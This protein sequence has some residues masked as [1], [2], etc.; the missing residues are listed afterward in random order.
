MTTHSNAFSLIETIITLAIAG[1]LLAIAIPSYRHHLAKVHRHQAQHA[2][3]Q[4]ATNLTH[5]YR[6]IG[7]YHT[8]SNKALNVPRLEKPLKYRLRISYPAA[9]K[10]IVTATPTGR[11]AQLDK[12]CGVLQI[13][14][15]DQRFA[16]G[17]TS[18]TDCWR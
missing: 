2:L 18:A 12:N 9:D 6:Q 8:A 1:I 15:K 16:S 13:N 5:F 3:A 10:F 14:E 4:L 17:N 11:Q 7:N